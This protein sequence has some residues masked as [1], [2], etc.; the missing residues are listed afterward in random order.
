MS[1]RMILVV[2]LGLTAAARLGAQDAV[3][4][5]L[6]K[7]GK[8]DSVLI[9][10]RATE[11]WSTLLTDLNGKELNTKQGEKPEKKVKT[12]V[13]RE[14]VFET[15]AQTQRP[16]RL[17]RAYQKASI[18]L[19]VNTE[20]L[21]VEGKTVLIERQ[22]DGKYTF[23]LKD[24]E[25]LKGEA[26]NLLDGEFNGRGNDDFDMRKSF[27]PPKAVKPG[28]SWT[29]DP[30]SLVR[31]YGT[32]LLADAEKAK[33]TGKLLSVRQEEGK[34]Y[35]RLEFL[36]ELPLKGFRTPDGS[37]MGVTEGSKMSMAFTMD[38]CI[39]GS[40]ETGVLKTNIEMSATAPIAA[41]DGMKLKMVLSSKVSAHE[42]RIDPPPTK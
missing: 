39:D 28:D 26:A 3:T 24:G 23:R 41:T 37:T 40:A 17:E 12:L 1:R 25:E 27:L 4:I 9:E 34:K 5:K 13:Y 14:S 10:Q 33:V 32:S 38:A 35:G 30:A 11:E 2:L 6:K 7:A 18:T 36:V 15:D 22:K 21:P 31:H 16:T 8:G 20:T 42:R 19:G 29:V